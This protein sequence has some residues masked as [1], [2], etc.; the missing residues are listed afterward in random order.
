[1]KKLCIALLL[2]GTGCFYAA[3]NNNDSSIVNVKEVAKKAALLAAGSAAQVGSLVLPM[4]LASKIFPARQDAMIAGIVGLYGMG[5]VLPVTIVASGA[6]AGVFGGRRM[7]D[8]LTKN[9]NIIV[10]LASFLF[11]FGGQCMLSTTLSALLVST[12]GGSKQAAIKF[13]ALL[14]A[15]AWLYTPQAKRLIQKYLSNR[16]TQSETSGTFIV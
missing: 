1:M 10:R 16:R 14:L 6:V 2:T 3:Q 11:G 9:E 15:N 12:L 13:L 7:D 8:V 4:Y 5:V